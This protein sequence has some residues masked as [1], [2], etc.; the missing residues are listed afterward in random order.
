MKAIFSKKTLQVAVALLV[1]TVTIASIVVCFAPMT[2]AETQF[3]QEEQN[4]ALN[5]L[6]CKFDEGEEPVLLN[7]KEVYNFNDEAVYAL[8]NFENYYMVVIRETG[9]ILERGDGASPFAGMNGK[10]YYGGFM[11]AFYLAADG[12]IYD[13]DNILV[14]DEEQEAM[15]T[16]M[17]DIRNRDYQ[18][19]LEAINTP[20]TYGEGNRSRLTK[21]GHSTTKHNYFAHDI[22]IYYNMYNSSTGSLRSNALNNTQSINVQRVLYT[23]KSMTPKNYGAAFC[24]TFNGKY[25]IYYP[26]NIYNACSLVSMTMLLQYYDRMNIRTDLIPSSLSYSTSFN[27]IKNNPLRSKTEAIML[28]LYNEIKVLDIV[29]EYFDGAATYLNINGAFKRYFEKYGINCSPRY[30]TSYT[31]VKGAIDAG[32][33]VI[34]TIGAGR[35]FY[36]NYGNSSYTTIGLSG[37]N[38]VAYGYTKNSIGI[39]DEFLVHTDWHVSTTNCAQTFMNKLYS[40]GNCYLEVL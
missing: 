32:N 30:F 28:S 12:N 26:K 15:E 21:L 22:N 23:V 14:S 16:A 6:Y 25:D 38:V 1:F 13:C 10:L 33:P 7:I 18:E 4:L 40:A 27:I 35:G 3:S 36:K 31:N 19:F 17:S 34:I 20:Q 29:G 39:M 9:T 11:E 2:V 37:H 8:Y 5:N 24:R